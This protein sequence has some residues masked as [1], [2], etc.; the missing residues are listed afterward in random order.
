M[1]SPLLRL[2]FAG[3]LLFAAFLP[4]AHAK[5]TSSGVLIVGGTEAEADAW[6]FAA[7]L[8]NAAVQDNFSAQFCGCSVI[9]DTWVLT[10]A[11]CVDDVPSPSEIEVL[12]GTH[13][14]TTGQGER[15]DVT[16]IVIHPGFDS[17]TLDNDVALLQLA[18]PVPSGAT[19]VDLY[20][21]AGSL[22][23]ELLTVVGWGR[24]EEGGVF[25]SVLMEL[26]LPWVSTETCQT[27]YPD[28]AIDED[29]IC[30]GYSEGGKDACQGDSGGPLFLAGPDGVRQVGIVSW[31]DGCAEA[32][33]YGV[34]TRITSYL[35][36]ID[37]TISRTAVFGRVSTSFAGH[38][39][40]PVIGAR[41][42]LHGTDYTATTDASG[43][44][45]IS[46][47]P[48]HLPAGSYALAVTMTGMH[49]YATEVALAAGRGT[50]ADATLVPRWGDMNR[51]DRLGLEDAAGVLKVLTGN[52]LLVVEDDRVLGMENQSLIVAVLA[53]DVAYNSPPPALA[54]VGPPGHG[55]VGVNADSTVSYTPAADYHGADAFSYTATSG[56]MTHSGNVYV[57]LEPD[58]SPRATDDFTTTTRWQPVQVDVLANDWH[59]LGLPLEV[60]G[61]APPESGSLSNSGGGILEYTPSPLFTGVTGFQYS[62]TD[63]T[64][65]AIG[66]VEVT[67][68]DGDCDGG[69]V[70]T[71]GP[72]PI[73]DTDPDTPAS[74]DIVVTDT[75]QSVGILRVASDIDHP[76][77]G[78]LHM[79]LVSPAGTVFVMKT[80]DGLNV[81][82]ETTCFQTQDLSSEAADGTWSLMVTDEVAGNTGTLNAWQLVFCDH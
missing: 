13:D 72:V 37:E 77:T 65:H 14:L 28:R 9:E 23:E 32:G 2:V 20:R 45:V 70:S 19:A 24:L 41:V 39:R 34:Y 51:D 61:I 30:A 79:Q 38:A 5:D 64:H 59:P 62:I 29:V 21:T 1:Q 60:N 50:R 52:P 73:P 40:L 63:G 25:A 82:L 48:E 78:E 46:D 68:T 27:A 8:L 3:V 44:Y 42:S 49:P 10:A 76:A 4:Q 56:D 18:R 26:D 54:G 74:S 12:A 66:T 11:H 22:P 81:D 16:R 15:I 80:A 43:E 33:K 7:A 35:D 58:P 36:F 69:Y 55:Q 53:N 67:V 31:G 75:G 71:D 17:L 6:P 47:Y 57:T